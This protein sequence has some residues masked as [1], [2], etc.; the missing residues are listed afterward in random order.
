MPAMHAYM[1]DYKKIVIQMKRSFY[2]GRS[3]YFYITSNAGHYLEMHVLSIDEHPEEV[4][5]C[6]GIEED[7][8]FDVEYTVHESHGLSVPL[9]MR[10][11]CQKERFSEEFYYTGRDLGATYTPEKTRFVLWAPTAVSVCVKLEQNGST[12]LLPMQREEKGVWRADADGDFSRALYTYIVRRNGETVESVDPYGLSSNANSEKSAVI[13]LTQLDSIQDYALNTMIDAPTDAVIY[14]C[15]VRDMTS[16]ATS[17][18]STHGKFVSLAQE[19]TSYKENWTGMSYLRNLGVTHVQLQPVMDFVTVDE[20]HPDRNYNWGYDPAQ[21][22]TLEGSYATDPKD[23]YVRMKEFRNLVSIFHK[24]DMR[25]TLDVVFNH[26]YDVDRCPF[27]KIVPYY[28]FRY[29]E[30]AHLSN[31]SYCG[32]DFSSTQ[33]MT[34]KYI[35]DVCRK[36][37]ELYHI[38]GYRF[39][40][41]GILDVTT[42]NT[43]RDEVRTLKKDALFYGEGWDM[44]TLLDAKQK[45]CIVNQN[46]MEDI[47]HFNDFFRDTV[48]GRT[49]D[50]SKYDKGYITGALEKAFDMCSA[51]T[52]N[53]L[54]DPYFY[55]F[56]SPCKTINSVETHDNGTAWDK[57]R[58]CCN[59]EAR[60]IRLRRMKMLNASVL[61]SIGVPFLHA[62]QEFCGTKNDNSNSYNAGDEINQMNWERM[63]LNR[64]IVSYTR[65]AISIRKLL[66]GFHLSTQEQVKQCVQVSVIEGN[67]VVM[68]IHYPDETTH[69]DTIR[70]IFNPTYDS[71]TYYYDEEWMTIFDENGNTSN[72]AKHDVYVPWLS[73]IVAVKGKNTEVA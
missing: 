56:D 37:V 61:F 32:N 62:G 67:M 39:D 11:I 23:P 49:S 45:A 6:T 19:H 47:G 72:Q 21:Y 13:D 20:L 7:L 55:R 66:K 10:M 30:T 53:V 48:K 51:I 57:M 59:E 46:V 36:L 17:G 41:M 9:E 31:G 28:Y 4:M 16:S 38:D 34:R 5:Y 2:Q 69:L 33:P 54:Q 14:E 24:N 40:L 60:D 3:D 63:C 71:R 52:G 25:V 18:S 27:Q 35:V 70:V 43:I 58:S 68:D 42:M 22:L 44:P 73:V 8:P 50:D 65:K 1:D 29:S 12:L 26:V 64:D 15:S